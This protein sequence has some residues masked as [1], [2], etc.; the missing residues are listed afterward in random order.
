MPLVVERVNR[1]EGEM[2]EATDFTK[3]INGTLPELHKTKKNVTIKER[4]DIS[5][6]K[7]VLE[8]YE[9]P[10]DSP[11]VMAPACSCR[12]WVGAPTFRDMTSNVTSYC[13][14]VRRVGGKP[15]R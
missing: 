13:T 6:P 15:P 12:P 2:P 3:G 14:M 5:E 8:K 10:G 9:E 7:D 11:G 1:K 4:C